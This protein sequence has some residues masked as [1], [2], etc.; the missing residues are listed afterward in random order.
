MLWMSHCIGT[1][2]KCPKGALLPRVLPATFPWRKE[3]RGRSCKHGRQWL[4]KWKRLAAE[5]SFFAHDPPQLGTQ[6]KRLLSPQQTLIWGWFWGCLPKVKE[7]LSNPREISPSLQPKQQV[8]GFQRP[9]KSGAPLPDSEIETQQSWL[10][11][12]WELTN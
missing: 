5:V 2:L 10:L 8:Q 3:P 6:R 7:S 1:K 9:A 12:C 11:G 4:Q